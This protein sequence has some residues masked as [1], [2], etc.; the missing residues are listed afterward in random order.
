M[1]ASTVLYKEQNLERR[2]GQLTVYKP[3][4]AKAIVCSRAGEYVVVNLLFEPQHEISNNV[5]CATTNASDQPAQTRSLIRAFG[6]RLNILRTE[7]HLEFLSLTG[8]CTDS[9]GSLLVKVPHCYGPNFVV[10]PIVCWF[11]MLGPYLLMR[12]MVSFLF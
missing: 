10:A 5:V 4:L 11:F 1:R 12:F 8:G 7:H 3:L 9:S 6:S 2:F